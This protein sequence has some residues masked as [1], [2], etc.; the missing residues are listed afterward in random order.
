[1]ANDEIWWC[2]SNGQQPASCTVEDSATFDVSK[3]NHDYVCNYTRDNN[4]NN[5]DNYPMMRVI[6]V[7]H[8][9]KADTTK[10]TKQKAG[11][12]FQYIHS[13]HFASM[14]GQT[15]G[16]W[17]GAGNCD[18]R[19]KLQDGGSIF[20]ETNS[21]ITSQIQPVDKWY[22]NNQV[23][24]EKVEIAISQDKMFV[25]SYS[26]LWNKN[27]MYLLADYSTY[28]NISSFDSEGNPQSEGYVYE[29]AKLHNIDGNNANSILAK[30]GSTN[31][32]ATPTKDGEGG[33]G[34]YPFAWE[35]SVYYNNS[36]RWL[37]VY[38][39]GSICSFDNGNYCF[40]VA[41]CFSF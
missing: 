32:N 13:V 15:E 10:T 36:Y 33:S 21:A 14:Q 41:P 25:P 31:S 2:N 4:Q 26:E 22:Q 16:C 8:D 34:P 35:R 9:Y 1:M 38:G 11:L 39:A 17:W 40:G 20:N 37:R 28:N 7:L 23:P 24:G 27:K 18:V 29:W 30:L 6:G 19:N 5:I 3:A 12:T